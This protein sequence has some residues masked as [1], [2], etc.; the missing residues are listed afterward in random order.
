MTGGFDGNIKVWDMRKM[1]EA[2][3]VRL[4]ADKSIWEA[5]VSQDGKRMGIP[6]IYD[7]YLFSHPAE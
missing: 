6:A 2:V 7:G 3:D 4:F 5:K 1:K